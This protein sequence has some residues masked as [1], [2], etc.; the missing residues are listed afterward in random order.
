[1]QH[2]VQKQAALLLTWKWYINIF[3]FLG[4]NNLFVWNET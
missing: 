2:T 1:M 4:T 3:I